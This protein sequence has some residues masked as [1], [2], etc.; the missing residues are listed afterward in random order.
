MKSVHRLLI[1]RRST[2]EMQVHERRLRGPIA[3]G[4]TEGNARL[5]GMTAAV[6]L[7]LLAVE[8]ATLLSLRSF[9]SW[10]IFVGMLLVPPV[11]LKIASTGYKFARYY[12]GYPAYRELGPPALALRLLGPVLVAS[13]VGLFATGV[14]LIAR[15]PG[16]GLLLLLHKASFVVW[17]AAMTLHVLGHLTK[18]PKL[19]VP[20]V[21]GGEG[22]RASGLRLALIASVIVAG[23]ILAVATVP[24]L[25]PWVHWFNSSH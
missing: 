20:D 3:T 15:G 17:V 22:V 2:G 25:G 18:I 24:L 7:V 11:V 8:G 6:L 14:A 9:L 5:T 21:R 12:L 4:G 23:A 16:G 10:H 19:T 13:T 1:A